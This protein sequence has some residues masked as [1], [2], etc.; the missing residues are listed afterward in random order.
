MG[1]LSLLMARN[2]AYVTRKGRCH[3]LQSRD[4]KQTEQQNKYVLVL[5]SSEVIILGVWFTAFPLST[6]PRLLP[7][8]ATPSAGPSG[9]SRV[10]AMA[11]TPHHFSAFVA[12][13]ELITIT[14]RFEMRAIPRLSAVLSQG[15]S[16]NSR[17]RFFGPF[18]A[19]YPVEVPLYLAL[20]LLRTG[21][22]TVSLPSY[23]EPEQLEKVLELE[24]EDE[25]NFQPLPFYFFEIAKELLGITS[26]GGGSNVGGASGFVG[27]GG[28]GAS[29]TGLVDKDG[30]PVDAP[31]IHRLVG[32]I[33]LVR[34]R[35][36]RQGTAVL[37][38]PDA[39]MFIPGIKLNNIV[40]IELEFLRHSLALVLQEGCRLEQQRRERIVVAPHLAGGALSSTAEQ[41]TPGTRPSSVGGDTA[42][43]PLSASSSRPSRPSATGW[44]P[45]LDADTS[46][47][48]QGSTQQSGMT[49]ITATATTDASQQQQQPPAGELGRA[50]FT[51]SVSQSGYSQEGR[52]TSDAGSLQQ[53]QQLLQPPPA[54]KRRIL[55]QT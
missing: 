13:D 8:M 54:K 18:A 17:H 40:S 6:T 7:L 22:C 31:T 43:L 55:R 26:A 33:H 5:G 3:H 32:D 14:P 21:I 1:C 27:G 29:A 34:Q 10:D 46:L 35:K 15:S 2:D 30:S 9:S 20:H 38:A 50:L 11:F 47:L 53:Q 49:S 39:Q 4:R 41:H 42:A 44:T 51:A 24:K 36:L 19:Q 12:L 52:G 48:L 23:L 28:A 37:E 16:S 25:V 45:L